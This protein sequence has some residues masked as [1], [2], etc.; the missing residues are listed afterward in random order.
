V[1]HE[2]PRQGEIEVTDKETQAAPKDEADWDLEQRA[3][4]WANSNLPE[5]AKAL[6]KDLWRAYCDTLM[7]SLAQAKVATPLTDTRFI[8]LQGGVTALFAT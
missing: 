3:F 2:V 8:R 4:Q 5:D 1:V 6:I 7:G